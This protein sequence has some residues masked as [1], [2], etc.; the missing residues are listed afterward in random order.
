MDHSHHHHHDPHQ[1]KQEHH[2]HVVSK[3]KDI[4][5]VHDKHAGHHTHDF[6]RRFWICLA[7]TIP[8]LILSHMIQQWL[9]FHLTF[10]GDKWILLALSS[11]IFIYGGQPFLKGLVSELKYRTPA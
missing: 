1:H 10:P 11:I 6:L 4:K 8:V 3:Q 5:P 2:H 7:L 9:G